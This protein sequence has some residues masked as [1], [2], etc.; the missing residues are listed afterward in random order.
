MNYQE[1]INDVRDLGFGDD[2]DMMDFGDRVYTSINRAIEEVNLKTVPITAKYEFEID[3]TDEGYLYIDMAEAVDGFLDFTDIPVM[4]ERDGTEYYTRFTDYDIEMT[5]T[6]VINADKHKGNFRIFYIKRHTP[7]TEGTDLLEELE[8]PAK[9][10]RLVALLAAYYLWEEDEPSR[11]TQLY[12]LFETEREE[13]LTKKDR[14][15]ARILS[16]GI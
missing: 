13:I 3:D 6:V 8:L 5:T 16:G 7:V 1:L 4:Y 2:A 15:K 12:N 14:P 11:A 10:Q 9:V